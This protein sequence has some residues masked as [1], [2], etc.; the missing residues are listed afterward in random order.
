VRTI[1]ADQLAEYMSYAQGRMRKKILGAQEA[2]Q[3]GVPRVY[4]GSASLQKVL[5]GSGTLI[6]STQIPLERKRLE[7]IPTTKLALLPTVSRDERK[8]L[9]S[10]G[11]KGGI[12]G[13]HPRN[14]AAYKIGQKY[15]SDH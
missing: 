1:P 6:E 3:G 7:A 13:I 10:A 14:S 12:Y 2:L 4:I 11:M 9:R 15:G 8:Y 5:H